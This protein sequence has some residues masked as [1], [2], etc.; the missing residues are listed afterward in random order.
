ML[1]PTQRVRLQSI[2]WVTATFKVFNNLGNLLFAR[3][4]PKSSQREGFCHGF[5]TAQ[6]T[7]WPDRKIAYLSS[8]GQ[9]PRIVRMVAPTERHQCFISPLRSNW[10]A[11]L[12]PGRLFRRDSTGRGSSFSEF[13]VSTVEKRS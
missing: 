13:L 4:L 12:A 5:A 9:E 3:S 10:S 8:T 2:F 11:A 6:P 7:S 1:L